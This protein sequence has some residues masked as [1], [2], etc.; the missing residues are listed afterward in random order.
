[1]CALWMLRV[2]VVLNIMPILLMTTL[3]KFDFS[4][5]NQNQVLESLKIFHAIIE[6][7]TGKKLKCVCVDNNDEYRGLFEEYC[8][9]HGI[10]NEKVVLKTP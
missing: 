7:E 10:K 2:L 3:E 9:V 5:K 4:F 6:K 8:K 1:M